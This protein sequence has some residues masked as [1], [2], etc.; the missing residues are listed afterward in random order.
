MKIVTLYTPTH[1]KMLEEFLLPSLPKDSR[2]KIK[3]VE[4]PQ[5]TGNDPVF[6]SP[7]WKQFM[8]IKA[9]LLWDELL[10]IPE[11]EVYGFF[12][13]DIIC[14]NNF[15]DYVLEQIKDVDFIAQND[16]PDHFNANNICTGVI[17]LKNTLNTRNLLKATNV[18]LNN[19]KNE[20]D[21]FTHFACNHKK[22]IELQNLKYKLFPN[23]I[24]W[25]YGSINGRVWRN[26]DFNFKIPDKNNLL[27]LHANFTMHEHKETLLN[28]FK[29]KLNG[30]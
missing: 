29:K 12:D 27:W 25:T 14:V 7:E 23:D 3:K 9:K 26:D 24:A 13:C 4:A 1:K 22:Y 30:L 21:S 15:Y 19:F 11:N 18:F 28:L 5:I 10:D 8:S 20:Q 17:F 16:A 6:N 2:I